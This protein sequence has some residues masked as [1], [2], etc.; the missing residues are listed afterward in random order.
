MTLQSHTEEY[1]Q[2]RRWRGHKYFEAVCYAVLPATVACILQC[3]ASAF[4]TLSH[5]MRFA[6]AR[7]SVGMGWSGLFCTHRTYRVEG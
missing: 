1:V 4:R 6:G 7:T 3:K 2:R 5:V